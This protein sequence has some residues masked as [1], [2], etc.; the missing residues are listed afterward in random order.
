MLFLALY[1]VFKC[2]E[3]LFFDSPTE[4]YGNLRSQKVPTSTKVFC[5]SLDRE[6]NPR[7]TAPQKYGL[8]TLPL[9]FSIYIYC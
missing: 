6:L 1:R 2:M 7:P 3:Q 5:D 8:S 9:W 4:T